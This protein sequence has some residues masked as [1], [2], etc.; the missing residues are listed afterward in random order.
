M[1]QWTPWVDRPQDRLSGR[2]EWYDSV[3][4]RVTWQARTP[5]TSSA[6]PTTSSGHATA[7]R[8]ARPNRTKPTSVRIASIRTGCSR[9]RGTRRSRPGCSSRRACAATISQ[10]NMYYNPGV[11]NDIVS[12]VDVGIGQCYGAPAVYLGHP[13]GRDRYTQRASL[14]YVT[15]SHN[16]K[17]GFQTDE[18]ETRTPTGTPTGTSTTTSSTAPRS[19][20]SSMPTPY[21]QKS[22]GKA[23]LGIYAPG[24]VEGH[25]QAHAQPR[26]AVGL[27]QQLRAGTDRRVRG[28]NR[29][30]LGRIAAD[31]P[32]ARPAQVRSGLQRANWKDFNPRLGV[33][34]DLFGNGKTALKV[35]LG[36]YTAKLGTEIAENGANPISTRRSR[37][38]FAGWTD[39][40]GNYVPGLRPG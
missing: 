10:W 19:A 39:T 26:P 22:R 3:L 34:Y 13:N 25:Q 24:S 5:R 32:L 8:S 40:N 38:T 16:F 14:S 17:A 33:A 1:V 9:R 28:R 21:L 6:S 23:D 15:G 12:I 36:R 11:T 20:F 27:L 7:G 30:L 29:R 4:G 37:L 18:A 31:Q 35:T 2:Q